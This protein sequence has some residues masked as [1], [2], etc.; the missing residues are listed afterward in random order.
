MVIYNYSMSAANGACCIMF[1]L[2]L[3]HCNQF[4]SKERDRQVEAAALLYWLLK[5]AELL[6]TVSQPLSL[7]ICA[8]W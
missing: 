2:A 6:D 1:V 8:E 4:Y 7:S 5:V 3:L